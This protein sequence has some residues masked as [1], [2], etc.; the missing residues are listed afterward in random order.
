M[1]VDYW[2]GAVASVLLAAYLLYSLARPE[3]F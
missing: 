1:T 2:L 3:R